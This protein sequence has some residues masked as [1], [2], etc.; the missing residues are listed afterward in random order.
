[1]FAA[2]PLAEIRL[3][4]I[5]PNSVPLAYDSG[6]RSTKR[7]GISKCVASL[8]VV[9]FAVVVC[10]KVKTLSVKLTPPETTSPS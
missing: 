8:I 5:V 1:M 2:V 10:S 3:Q 4:E 9:V 6:A 7:S